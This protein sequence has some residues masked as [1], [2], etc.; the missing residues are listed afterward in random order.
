MQKH[1]ENALKIAKYLESNPNVAVVNYPGLKSSKYYKLVQK[2][3]PKGASSVFTFE[4][5]GGR[6]AGAKFIDNIKLFYHVANVGD[7]RSIV[8][9]PATTTHSQLSDEQLKNSGITAGTIR[10][11]IGLEDANALIAAL[12]QAIDIASK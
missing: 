7:T 3:L 11:S 6:E 1:S 4:L 9:H 10:L 2:Y 8:T 5:K 12:G